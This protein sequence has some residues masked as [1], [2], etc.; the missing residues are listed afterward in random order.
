M[1]RFA[2]V[3]PRCE[4]VNGHI[5]EVGV[6]HYAI[7]VLAPDRMYVE[8]NGEGKIIKFKTINKYGFDYV[9]QIQKTQ[10]KSRYTTDELFDSLVKDYTENDLWFLIS[11]INKVIENTKGV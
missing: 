5:E 7:E 11:F 2:T 9:Y 1:K 6:N 3:I 4:S 8:R 10:V